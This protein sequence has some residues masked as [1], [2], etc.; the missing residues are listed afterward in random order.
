MMQPE[1]VSAVILQRRDA[2]AE[3]ILVRLYQRHPRLK[4]RYDEVE[5]HK[6]LRDLRY[7]L[8]YLA[9]ALTARRPAL[10]GDYVAWVRPVLESYGVPLSILRMSLRCTREVLEQE[11]AEATQP[12]LDR[13]WEI[14]EAPLASETVTVP[15]FIDPLAPQG[16]VAQRYL[17]LL[18]H[19]DRRR[20]SRL[21][22]DLVEDVPVR[23][24]YLNVFQPVQYEI[25][26]LWQLNQISV[27]QEHY[28]TAVTQLVM[29]QLYPR[30]FSTERS[31]RTLVATCVG[32]ELHEIGV[33][34]VADFFEMA[35]WDTFYLGANTPAPSVVRSV[36]ERQADVLA[37]SATITLHVSA[38]AEL[39]ASVR[40][41]EASDVR[42]LVGG[43]PFN[44]VPD[45]WC[46]VGADGYAADAEAAID[47]AEALV[48][49]QEA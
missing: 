15:S 47:V 19:G 36:I 30:I 44:Q 3:A 48:S 42:V 12:I 43:Y 28:A 45:L 33:R 20:A 26:R 40:D 41:S 39:I 35:G 34:M 14:G 49:R 23:S 27:A 2:L 46:Q 37:V 21:I 6:S 11:L 29:S 18:L 8:S 5:H 17:D 9:E 13:Y 7:H 22:L 38:V 4:A 31:G 24:V 25:G 1:D 10:F 16:E 32:D